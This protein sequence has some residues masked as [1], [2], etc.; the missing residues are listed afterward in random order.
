MLPVTARRRMLEALQDDVNAWPR[1]VKESGVKNA[2]GAAYV[3]LS[4]NNEI[5]RTPDDPGATY[6]YMLRAWDGR[7]AERGSA[8]WDRIL[9][10][11]GERL[12]WEWF[13]VDETRPYGPLFSDVRERIRSA[14]AA[15]PG[16]AVYKQR[17]EEKRR[18]AQVVA[19]R[20]TGIEEEMRN[21]KRK[22]PNL[23]ELDWTLRRSR[24]SVVE[25][26]RPAP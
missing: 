25:R 14:L 3:P 22:R 12:L 4:R 21:G 10:Q 23:S 1:R 5:L 24:R 8:G 9:Q 18:A 17:N 13:M 6:A 15:H 20:L 16:N 7:S 26:G 2:A 11:A 19:D